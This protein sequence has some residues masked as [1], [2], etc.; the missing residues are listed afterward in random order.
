MIL[1]MN[2]HCCDGEGPQD[3]QI[4]QTAKIRSFPHVDGN[5]ALHVYMPSKLT[6][7]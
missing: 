6:Y 1:M 5:Y 7:C 2:I 4:S 3:M